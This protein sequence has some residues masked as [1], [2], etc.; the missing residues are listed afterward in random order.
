MA[1]LNVSVAV[2]RRETL[3]KRHEKK[4]LLPLVCFPLQ[5]KKVDLV[6][7]SPWLLWRYVDIS[8]V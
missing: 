2:K 7:T 3:K 1:H 5:K 6:M 4:V 8:F